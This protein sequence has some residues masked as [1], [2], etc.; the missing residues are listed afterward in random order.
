[1]NVEELYWTAG[2]FE[3]EGCMSVTRAN[4]RSGGSISVYVGMT[5]KDVIDRLDSYWPGKRYVREHK[6]KDWKPLYLWQLNGLEAYNFVKVMYP[7]LGERRKARADELIALW[8]SPDAN[9]NRRGFLRGRVASLQEQGYTGPMIAN[10]LGISL[11]Y[12]NILK[13]EARNQ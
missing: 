13:R 4:R 8:E 10:E 2:I 6:G 12:V 9:H 3:G 11:G 5:D 1:M 7:I